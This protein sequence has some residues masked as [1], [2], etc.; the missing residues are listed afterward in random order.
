VNAASVLEPLRQAADNGATVAAVGN[1]VVISGL[2]RDV[3]A[4]A[5]RLA[6][7]DR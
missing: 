5:A 1:Q 4:L 2:V 6:E 3:D 7:L